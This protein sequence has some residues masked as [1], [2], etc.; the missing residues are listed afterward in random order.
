MNL[1]DRFKLLP[2]T[3]AVIDIVLFHEVGLNLGWEVLAL[4]LGGIAVELVVVGSELIVWIEC[5][6]GCRV[7][8]GSIAFQKPRNPNK[9]ILKI[10]L[11]QSQ[12]F[13]HI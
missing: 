10:S 2:I 5:A 1:R 9:E 4:A 7:M 3:S 12:N 13:A 6:G 11:S 8:C